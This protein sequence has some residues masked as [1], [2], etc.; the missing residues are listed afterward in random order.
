MGFISQEYWSRLSF[1]SPRDL[2]NSGIEPG[3]L[4]C[5]QI[6]YQALL[7][8]QGRYHGMN[9]ALYFCGFLLKKR[10]FIL[11]MKNNQSPIEE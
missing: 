3:H 4:N 6:L 5:R 11:T 9:M 10:N 2:T 1:P 7:S 8:Y